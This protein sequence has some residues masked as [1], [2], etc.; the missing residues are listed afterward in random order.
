MNSLEPPPTLLL[1]GLRPRLIHSVTGV[2]SKTYVGV[3][4]GNP[5]NLPVCVLKINSANRCPLFVKLLQDSLLLPYS[6][7]H[8]Q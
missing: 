4:D 7:W 1:K 8:T 2:R 6:S 3:K 5:I